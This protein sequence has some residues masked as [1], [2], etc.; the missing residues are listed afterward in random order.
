ML[1]EMV[2]GAGAL[3]IGGFLYVRSARAR[4]YRLLTSR[5]AHI[6]RANE[7]DLAAIATESL[8]GFADR[9]AALPDF[10]P[11]PSFALLAGE[12]ARLAAGEQVRGPERSY[13]PT[14]KQGGTLAYETL[15]ATA[16]ALV[17]CYHAQGLQDVVGRLIGVRISPTPIYDQS[18]LSLLVYD[19]PGDHIGWHYDHNFYRGRH[20]TVLL[21]LE[22]SGR[23]A[24]DLSHALLKVRLGEREIE[25]ASAPNTL[26]AFEGACVRHRVTPI[27]DGERRLVLSMT[28]CTDPTSTWWQGLARRLKDTAYFGVR[29][30]WT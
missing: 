2:I 20:F 3:A 8:P 1:A 17:A 12:A 13:V 9:F 14:H 16:P 30:L 28:Y 23:A 22:N 29:A 19:K 18:S 4:L 26:I 15:I 6:T 21:T 11:A 27:Q 7:L 5:L 24:G 25:V 10:L